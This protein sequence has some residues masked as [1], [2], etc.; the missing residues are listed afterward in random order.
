[1]TKVLTVATDFAKSPAGRYFSDGPN[2]GERFRE[3]LLY[4]ALQEGDVEVVLDGVLTMG[5]SF[6]DEAFGGL[7]R[8]KK[9]TPVELRKKLV[10]KSRLQTY[11]NKVWSYIDDPKNLTRI[12]RVFG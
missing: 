11:V 5:S 9:C 12:R 4:P 10:V 2:S 8:E 1:M 6:L 3:E 7:V